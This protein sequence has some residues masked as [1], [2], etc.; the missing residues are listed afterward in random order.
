MQQ[1]ERYAPF[2]LTP[3]EKWVVDEGLK[4][5]TQQLVAN[6]HTIETEPWERT[7]TSAALLDLSA[8]PLDGALINNQGT[9]RFVCDIKPGG[10]FNIERHM[11]EEIFYVVKGR[12]AT[13]VWYEGSPKHTFEWQEGSV[14]SI[15]LKPRTSEP[16]TRSFAFIRV[17]RSVASTAKSPVCFA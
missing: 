17:K 6:I 2:S 3:Y 16:A 12:G 7:G 15:P 13:S 9:I 10:T 8:D 5:H 4:V 14:F 1:S 11:Y